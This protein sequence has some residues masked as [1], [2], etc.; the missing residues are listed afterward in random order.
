MTNAY[1]LRSR[2][3]LTNPSFG[4]SFL[5]DAPEERKNRLKFHIESGDY[6]GTLST[7]LAL[8]ADTLATNDP[9]NRERCIANLKEL[10]EDLTYL[11]KTHMIEHKR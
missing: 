11:Q 10:R 2:V 8:M 1:A 5:H 4:F 9:I 3:Y 7:I 6:F